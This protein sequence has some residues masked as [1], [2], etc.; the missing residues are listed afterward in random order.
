[1][2][3]GTCT[4]LAIETSFDD[5]CMAII[6]GGKVIV[7]KRKTFANTGLVPVLGQEFH[8][9]QLPI[10]LKQ[11]PDY[12]IISCTRG[13]GM[14]FCLKE[15][16]TLANDLAMNCHK[17][18]LG[19]HH[20]EA[21][22]LSPLINNDIDY[23]YLC[24]IASGGHTQ[25]VIVHSPLQFELIGSALDNAIGEVYDKISRLFNISTPDMCK[26]LL[27]K[28]SSLAPIPIMQSDK[29]FNFSFS[30]V[31]SAIVRMAN[32]KQ[33]SD[34]ELM[35]LLQSS[36]LLHV[37]KRLEQVLKKYKI[38][39]LTAA[40]GAIMN[41]ALQVLLQTIAKEHKV[42]LVIPYDYLT[43]NAAMIGMCAYFQL[44]ANRPFDTIDKWYYS[45]WEY[46]R[47]GKK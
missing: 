47:I 24:F 10:L 42:P 41:P 2:K 29:S 13:P 46:N 19:I 31:K 36:C 8:K 37:K 4:I 35:L 17:P 44:K 3:L 7:N 11:M 23:P 34:L 16:W 27:N 43:D 14:A 39:A 6:Q 20:M 21:H 1:M 15:G 12:D 25:L 26:L 30:G 33:H 38:K 5:T 18:L 45:K 22:C 40:G 9:T 28:T 32:A